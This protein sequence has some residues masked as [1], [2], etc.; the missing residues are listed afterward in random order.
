MS[1][2]DNTKLVRQFYQAIEK[3]DFDRALS[4]L[5]P[6]IVWEMVPTGETVRGAKAFAEAQEAGKESFPDMKMKIVSEIASENTVAC[7][8]RCAGTHKGTLR[9]PQGDMPPTGKR[10]EMQVF[11]IWEFQNGKVTRLRSY[12]DTTGMMQQLGQM[13]KAA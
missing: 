3:N 6:N 10:L 11:D 5:D 12:F 9:T 13:G 1:A 7:E 8:L 4:I 2:Q